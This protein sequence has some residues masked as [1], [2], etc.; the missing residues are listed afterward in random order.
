MNGPTPPSATIPT[1][2]APSPSLA[3]SEGKPRVRR[4]WTL[5]EKAE[6][7]AL[8]A[9]SGLTQVEYCEEM[10]ISPATFSLWRRQSRVESPAEA[11]RDQT[12]AEVLVTERTAGASPVAPLTATPVVIHLCGGARIEVAVGTDPSWLASLLKMLGGD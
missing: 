5:E 1:I 6:H 3:D 4:H 9:E 12:F 7:L 10:G 8:F 2:T 11:A